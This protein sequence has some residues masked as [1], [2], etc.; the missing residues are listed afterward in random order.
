MNDG[1]KKKENTQ[2]QIKEGNREK[3]LDDLFLKT[4]T[5]PCI[6]Y[7]PL[8]DEEIIIS[9]ILSTDLDNMTPMN[10]LQTISRWKKS[11][12]GK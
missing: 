11:L 8:S 7:K 1:K 9:E 5:E 6:Y 10:A 4:K 3:T 2:N 12:S